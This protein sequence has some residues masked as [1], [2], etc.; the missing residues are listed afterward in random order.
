MRHLFVII[1]SGL[2]IALP[3]CKYFKGGA[4]SGKKA[5]NM[6][7]MK[8]REDST[9]F[10]DS[11]QKIK[12]NEQKI[13]NSKLDSLR[14]ADEER[15]VSEAKHKYNIIVGS[16]ITPGYAAGL[17]EEY[18]KQGYDAKIIKAEGSRFEY[19]SVEALDNFKKAVM[20]L[21][22]FQDTVQMESWLYVKK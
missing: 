15:A 14:R 18:R 11:L 7:V 16:F 4:F 5:G 3:S 19:V 1:L 10:A 8:S 17:T 22:Q 12:E 9:R 2:L 21:R 6:A 13:D 20:R